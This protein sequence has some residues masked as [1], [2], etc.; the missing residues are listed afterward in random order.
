[1]RARQAIKCSWGR[2]QAS[3]SGALAGAAVAPITVQ[4]GAFPPGAA[5]LQHVYA[6]GGAQAGSPVQQLGA[7]QQ[8]YGGQLVQQGAYPGALA[9][10]VRLCSSL[11]TPLP[12]CRPTPARLF[13]RC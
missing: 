2:H 3:K 5:A 8:L 10:Q 1:M 7:Q 9:Y 4:A 11:P 13:S 12:A 6:A